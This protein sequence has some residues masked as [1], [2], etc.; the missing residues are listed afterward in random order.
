VNVAKPLLEQDKI[1]FGKE[2]LSPLLFASKSRPGYSSSDFIG[3]TQDG[4]LAE[5]ISEKNIDIKRLLVSEEEAIFSLVDIFSELNE[6]RTEFM[7][8][9]INEFFGESFIADIRR[10]QSP[11]I[12]PMNNR[13]E[14]R[15]KNFS[16]NG[17][18][19][20]VPG[21]RG[22]PIIN[23]IPP[24]YYFARTNTCPL[25]KKIAATIDILLAHCPMTNAQF[26]PMLV[27]QLSMLDGFLSS[28]SSRVLVC[29]IIEK[30]LQTLICLKNV[31]IRMSDIEVKDNASK[32]M[33]QRASPRN[34][35]RETRDQKMKGQQPQLRREDSGGYQNTANLK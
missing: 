9:N 25:L 16:E 21:L 29:E 30:V 6:K 26:F 17:E 32:Q 23:F 22:T 3:Q 10:H 15:S 20:F 28:T 18:H 34:P 8:V 31:F 7:R 24:A 13:G 11:P 4:Q 19:L 5:N 33:S 27:A 2:A 35:Y 1:L 14:L 12:T